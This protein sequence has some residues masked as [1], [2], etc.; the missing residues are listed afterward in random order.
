M[1]EK[2]ISQTTEDRSSIIASFFLGVATT[3]FILL[4]W[5]SI[6]NLLIFSF[7][8]LA[9]FIIF[10]TVAILLARTKTSKKTVKITHVEAPKKEEPKEKPST[11]KPLPTKSLSLKKEISEGKEPLI[12][13]EIKPKKPRKKAKSRKSKVKK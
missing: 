6:P 13:K 12:K 4:Y 1:Q 9:T 2:Q 3:L 8:S 11:I 7:L 10:L 5:L